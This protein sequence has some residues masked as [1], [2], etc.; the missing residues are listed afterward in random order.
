MKDRFSS[1]AVLSRSQRVLAVPVL[2]YGAR[3]PCGWARLELPLMKRA[4]LFRVVQ[5]L[6]SGC[7]PV[8]WK[9]PC[10]SRLADFPRPLC[11][12]W[13]ACCS[14]TLAMGLLPRRM[15]PLL[16]DAVDVWD[17][18]LP[19]SLCPSRADRQAV[20]GSPVRHL[21]CSGSP[22]QPEPW[23]PAEAFRNTPTVS[24]LCPLTL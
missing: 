3:G 1:F 16:L 18:L 10:V 9:E 4:S 15:V 13:S 7:P 20:R 8:L 22:R 5:V 14:Q 23:V 12:P 6:A 17:M 24:T 11:T 2:T 19:S 21:A